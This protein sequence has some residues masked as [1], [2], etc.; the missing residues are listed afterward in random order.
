MPVPTNVAAN[1]TAECGERC[2]LLPKDYCELIAREFG[3]TLDDFRMLNPGVN[4]K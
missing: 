3:L 4:E 2:E 1:T